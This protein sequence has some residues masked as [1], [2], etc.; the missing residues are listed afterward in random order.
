MLALLGL[1]DVSEL[2]SDIPAAVR[3]GLDLPQGMGEMEVVDYLATIL[4]RNATAAETPCFLGAGAYLHYVPAAVE[5]ILSRSEFYTSYTPYQPEISQGMLQAL[6][7]YQSLVCEITA[8]DAANSSMYDGSTA[9]GEAARMCRRL[10]K[11]SHFL[12]PQAMNRDKVSV[13]ENYLT[14]T[15]VQLLRYAYDDRDG[16]I[17][18]DEVSSLLSAEDVCGVYAEMPNFFGV[19][20][21]GLMEL[22]DLMGDSP[23]VLGV[24][25]LCLGVTR[26]P[27]DMGAD[28]V[29]G[30]GQPLG[31]RLSY[32]GPML[33]LFA[34]RQEHVR[35]MP[36]RV[37]GLTVDSRGQE[38]FCLTLQ[39]REQH[40]R[41][42]SATSNICTNEAL[43]A[44]GAAVFLSLL[45]GEG[46]VE[47][48]KRN[49][50][51]AK[52]LMG[53]MGRIDLV[54]APRFEAYHFNEF[55]AELPVRPEKVN[56]LLLAKGIIGG[57]PIADH[58]PGMH[59]SMLIAST[60][61]HSDQMQDDLV[62]ALREVL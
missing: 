10:H 52:R 31:S 18:L 20:D 5:H 40:I 46:L 47:L 7:E 49:M 21:P 41:R 8:M 39:T 12:I 22:K 42:S 25:P 1:E 9:L 3:R 32:G 57:L 60:E 59:N 37:V 16:C 17:V 50:E 23:L 48:G 4:R 44:V 36:G 19:M 43:N 45:G 55:V 11:G 51:R 27:G 30:E 33:G 24:N 54:K 2:F 29:V 58:I 62:R 35:K 28:I 6:F 38:A 61:M 14:G 56:R 26:P 53:M 13:L 34:C 15:G